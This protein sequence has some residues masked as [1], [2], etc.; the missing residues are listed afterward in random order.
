MNFQENS[1]EISEKVFNGCGR[2][3]LGR[4]VRDT[5]EIEVGTYQL[6]RNEQKSN[7]SIE[8]L[9]G[10]IRKKAKESR[11]FWGNLPYRICNNMGVDSRE[12]NQQCWNG[13]HVSG[14]DDDFLLI[15]C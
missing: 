4:R 10:E 1:Q 5:S 2:P 15:I 9:I 6:G 13:T 14:Y 8:K 12:N 3:N 7:P 11:G